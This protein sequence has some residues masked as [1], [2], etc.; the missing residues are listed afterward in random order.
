MTKLTRQKTITSLQAILIGRRDALRLAMEGNFDDLFIPDRHDHGDAS[1]EGNGAEI[2]S[3]LAEVESREL[4][5]IEVALER[6]RDGNYGICEMCECE[7]D[8]ARLQALPYASLCLP[9]QRE[10]EKGL[11]RTNPQVG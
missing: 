10:V 9:C 3:Q 1:A 4:I 5:Y 8:L 7:I 2:A 11:R 6:I